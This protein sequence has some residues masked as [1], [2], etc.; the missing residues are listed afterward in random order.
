LV[1]TYYEE[2]TH[3]VAVDSFVADDHQRTSLKSVESNTIK[4]FLDRRNRDDVL[5]KSEGGIPDLKW[6]FVKLS[7]A[8]FRLWDVDVCL[9]VDLDEADHDRWSG[10]SDDD[11]YHDLVEELD[12][13]IGDN[14]DG[15]TFGVEHGEFHARSGAQIAGRATFCDGSTPVEPFDLLAFRSD[16]EDAAGIDTEEDDDD[17]QREKLRSFVDEGT[18]APMHEVL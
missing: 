10:Q 16:L 5:V 2:V 12:E 8:L 1:E 14:Y 3:S 4:R 17:T 7:R 13:R 9:V 18:A 6:L 15:A 11:R